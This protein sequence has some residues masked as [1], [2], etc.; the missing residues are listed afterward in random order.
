MSYN[1]R[2]K[3]EVITFK[4]EPHLAEI[5]KRMPNRSRFIRSAILSSLDHLCPLCQGLGI[6]SPEQRGHWLEFIERHGV[7]ISECEECGSVVLVRDT[8]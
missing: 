2:H 6:L 5:L 4:V 7:R 1:G 8:Q 3:E